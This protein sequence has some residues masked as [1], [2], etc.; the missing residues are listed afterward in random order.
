MA[1]RDGYYFIEITWKSGF[2][3]I[4]PCRGFRLK[5]EIEFNRSIFWIESYHYYEVTKEQYEERV[6][7]S[8]SLADTEKTTSTNNTKS[9][10]KAKT[11]TKTD[12]T[13]P[14]STKR[15]APAA[16]KSMKEKVSSSKPKKK[17]QSGSVER[18]K[19]ERSVPTAKR[20][21][22]ARTTA[23]EGK[24][25]SKKDPRKTRSTKSTGSKDGEVGTKPNRRKPKPA[26]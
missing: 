5:S 13:K 26:P 18:K 24:E 15:S 25:A 2:K 16:K 12:G 4:V 6:W 17:P 11:A 14:S 9:S 10:R 23:Q 21:S 1:T 22:K 19:N 3:H 8:G 7:G 20:A